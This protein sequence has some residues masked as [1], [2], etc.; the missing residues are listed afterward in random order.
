MIMFFLSFLETVSLM[1]NVSPSPLC[2]KG[3]DNTIYTKYLRQIKFVHKSTATYLSSP[4]IS[5]GSLDIVVRHE[6]IPTY[7]TIFDQIYT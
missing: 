3:H 4:I 5:A 1:Y 6:T 7:Q 2:V